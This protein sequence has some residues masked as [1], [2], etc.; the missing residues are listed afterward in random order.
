M[1]FNFVKVEFFFTPL[2]I[3]FSLSLSLSYS[4]VYAVPF[5]VGR[6]LFRW[7]SRVFWRT[8]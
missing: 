6:S 3:L 7:E 1:E 8:S 2:P 4:L 5:D